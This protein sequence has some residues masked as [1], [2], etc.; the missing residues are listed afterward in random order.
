M[1]RPL[2]IVLT[3][4]IAGERVVS[5]QGK[6]YYN[7]YKSHC[8]KPSPSAHTRLNRYNTRRLRGDGYTFEKIGNVLGVSR[9][10]AYQIFHNN[11]NKELL[12]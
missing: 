5:K 8:Y 2:H 11:G 9:Q 1:K 10:R 3:K 12:D 7:Y 6:P 4:P